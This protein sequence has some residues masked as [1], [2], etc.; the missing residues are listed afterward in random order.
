MLQTNEK[1]HMSTRCLHDP[2]ENKTR[3]LPVPRL[4][5]RRVVVA[6]SCSPPTNPLHRF[7]GDNLG[8]NKAWNLKNQSDIFKELHGI[9]PPVKK[10]HRQGK[11]V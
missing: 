8:E 11:Y 7:P 1:E 9:Y 10:M 3:K 2:E 5:R 4:G 6:E